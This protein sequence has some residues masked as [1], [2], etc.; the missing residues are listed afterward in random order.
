MFVVLYCILERACVARIWI[1]LRRPFDASPRVDRVLA[2]VWRRLPLYV[3]HEVVYPTGWPFCFLIAGDL[4]PPHR[5]QVA[6]F[7][8][9]SSLCGDYRRILLQC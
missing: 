5:I 3:S 6:A 9:G 7:A 8:S 1:W 2:Y 4:R